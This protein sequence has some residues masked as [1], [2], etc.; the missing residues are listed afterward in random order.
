MRRS[1]QDLLGDA[2]LQSEIARVF[3]Q[4]VLNKTISLCQGNFNDLERLPDALL[5]HIQSFLEPKDVGQ[6]LRVS[7][8]FWELS[9]SEGYWEKAVRQRYI[10]L[11]QTRW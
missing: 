4:D 5:Q 10:A 11:C 2:G 1:H 9:Q 3:G 7:R 6:L 8:R